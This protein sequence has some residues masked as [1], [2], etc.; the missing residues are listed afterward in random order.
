MKRKFLSITLT[1][2]LCL[3]LV[4]VFPTSLA[5]SEDDAVSWM[6]SW[7]GKQ[8]R[9]YGG[10]CVA[11]FDQY[12]TDVFGMDWLPYRVGSAYQLYD[13]TYP[14]GWTKIPAGS[15]NGNYRVGDILVWGTGYSR[16]GHVG[17]I[18]SV[19][20][21]SVKTLEQHKVW[22]KVCYYEAKIWDLYSP[23]TL[24]GLI[25][26]NFGGISHSIIGRGYTTKGTEVTAL[27][28]MLNTVNDAGLEADGFFG[29]KTEAAVK[30][31]QDKKGLSADGIVGEK[32][33]AALEADYKAATE[34]SP[35]ETPRP[36]VGYGFT[37][38][39]DDVKDM[40]IM[41]NKVNNAA[42]EEDGYF[43]NASQSALMAY[44]A[45]KGLDADGICGPLTWAAL[46]ADYQ[47]AQVQPAD[48]T[49]D[50]VRAPAQAPTCTV[51][52][53]KDY[54]VCSDCGKVFSD[55]DGNTE[56]TTEAMTVQALGHDYRDGICIRCGEEDPSYVPSA[57]DPDP[58]GEPDPASG[59][60][61][62]PN[63]DPGTEPGPE[64]S[65]L[66]PFR[67]VA[68]SAYY[69]DAVLWAFYADPQITDGISEDLFGPG[70]TVT[71]GQAMAFLWRAM[72]K[73]APRNAYCPFYD[74][75][76]GDYYYDAVLW[77][78]Q[79]GV[80]LGTS[81]TT[82]SPGDTLSTRHIATFLYRTLNPGRDGWNDEAEAWAR[83]SDPQKG[84]LPFGVD[85]AI[86]DGT[87]C[88]RADVVTFLYRALG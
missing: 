41:L 25:R 67:D 64:V 3:S 58:S 84:G 82:F 16:N 81:E 27:Q 83:S 1:F 54:W 26:P 18:Y 63:T 38:R 66:N 34:P 85:I 45:S 17:I 39:G 55:A 46:E 56:T 73:P 43:G 51:D 44:Q 69:C 22:N 32:T 36:R 42:L 76:T 77:A 5:A 24:R 8:V 2:F 33:W 72:G 88:P 57:V 79:N 80:T 6:N 60:D 20:G 15:I 52:G 61:S 11:L 68:E 48:H 10:E 28:T 53:N 9:E 50:L 7:E 37:T 78:T 47:A 29:V 49:H 14:T 59:P 30:A 87:P 86:S 62:G 71:R 75:T 35:Q 70:Q 23:N 31:Y 74:I 19:D 65:A 4:S 12:I 21:S 13:K 40:Q